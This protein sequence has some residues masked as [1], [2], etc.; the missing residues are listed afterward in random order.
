MQ[1]LQGP[2]ICTFNNAEMSD[3]EMANY[4]QKVG[5]SDKAS[6]PKSTGRFGKG[7]LTQYSVT[8]NPQTVSG[9]HYLMLDPHRRLIPNQPSMRSNLVDRQDAHYS[10]YTAEAPGQLEPLRAVTAA[11][12][13][14]PDFKVGTHYGGTLFRLPLRTPEA[15]QLSEISR[16]ATTCKDLLQ[17]EI[18]EFRRMAPGLLLFLRAVRK[19][20]VWVIE[21]GASKATLLHECTASTSRLPLSAEAAAR[22]MHV[23]SLTVAVTDSSTPSQHSSS[24]NFWVRCLNPRSEGETAGIAALLRINSNQ[25]GELPTVAGKVHDTLPL[26]LEDTGLPVHINGIFEMQSDRRNLSSGSGNERK[27]CTVGRYDLSLYL[28]LATSSHNATKCRLSYVTSLI[29]LLYKSATHH[30]VSAVHTRLQSVHTCLHCL[31]CSILLAF[32]ILPL[33]HHCSPVQSRDR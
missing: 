12:P 6:K 1:V 30:H 32:Y 20:S 23:D 27:V 4:V 19:I 2:A 15:A 8:D 18:Q 31:V 33:M 24:I 26:P 10:D 22:P 14:M 25:D 28:S 11:C 3:L 5:V 21:A 13:A 29:V 16:E 17:G 9:E 7:G